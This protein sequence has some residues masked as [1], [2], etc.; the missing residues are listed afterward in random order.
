MANSTDLLSSGLD[1]ARL[2]V[3]DHS[4]LPRSFSRLPRRGFGPPDTRGDPFVR[5]TDL[6]DVVEPVHQVREAAGT[7]DHVDRVDIALLIDLDE[8]GVQARER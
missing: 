6:V 8:P 1:G 4:K 5:R 2:R 7:E 3:D